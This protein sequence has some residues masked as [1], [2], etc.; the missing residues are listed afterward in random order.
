[1]RRRQFLYLLGCAAAAPLAAHAQ[2]ASIPVIGFLHGAAREPNAHLLA[3]FRQTL[4]DSGYVEGKNVSIEYRF[5]EHEYDRLPALAAD[6]VSRRVTVIYAD[7][8]TVTAL[9]AK[10][11]TSAIPIVFRIGA[12]PVKAGLVKSFSRPG[13]NL[14]GVTFITDVVIAKRFELLS[15]LLPDVRLIGVLLDPN[16]PNIDIRAKDLETAAKSLGRTIDVLTAGNESGLEAVFASL[17]RRGVTALVVQGDPFFFNQRVRLAALAS[18]YVI[19]TIYEQREYAA[20]GGLIA[21]GTSLTES[22]RRAASY[23]AKILQGEHPADLPVERPTK[24]ELIINLR[25]AKALALTLPPTL[26]ARAD[27][28]IE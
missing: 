10:A 11:A 13:G 14:T 24:F 22:Y 26:L 18:K 5:A 23:V 27:E 25:T 28:V 16:N 6:L 20:A 1:M 8:G 17:G 15:E 9:A 7:G 12:D 19:P 3:A 4:S 21:Y 2:Q